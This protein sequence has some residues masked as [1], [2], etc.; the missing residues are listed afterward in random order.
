MWML[1][2]TGFLGGVDEDVLKWMIFALK[3][4][5]H[6]KWVNCTVYRLQLNKTVTKQQ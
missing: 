4:T 6:F 3:T 5:V 2:G 1:M